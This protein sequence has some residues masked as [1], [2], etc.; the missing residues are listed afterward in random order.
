MQSDIKLII[1]YIAG[2]DFKSIA[3]ARHLTYSFKADT[4]A[5]IQHIIHATIDTYAC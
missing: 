2:K 4:P 5:L 1:L 3:I